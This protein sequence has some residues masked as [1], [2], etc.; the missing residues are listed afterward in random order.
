MKLNIT[1][2]HI[3]G[4]LVWPLAAGYLVLVVSQSFISAVCIW[5]LFLAMCLLQPVVDSIPESDRWRRSDG[6]YWTL[7]KGCAVIRLLCLGAAI[8]RIW[9]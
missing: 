1:F 2:A 4:A 9:N 6:G 7:Y 8:W 3:L 5:V